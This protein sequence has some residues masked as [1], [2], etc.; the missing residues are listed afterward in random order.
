MM[1]AAPGALTAL[2]VQSSFPPPNLKYEPP[3]HILHPPSTAAADMST[4]LFCVSLGKNF[5]LRRSEPANSSAGLVPNLAYR[6][7]PLSVISR[8]HTPT[9]T[10]HQPYPQPYLQTLYQPQYKPEIHT[11]TPTCNHICGYFWNKWGNLPK[12]KLNMASK[13]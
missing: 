12:D 5:S 2:S 6:T 8:I 7:P 13:K 3:K 4:K 1:P 10:H 11:T 9:F